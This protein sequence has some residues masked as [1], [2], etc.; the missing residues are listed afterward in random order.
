MAA[1]LE[2]LSA[3]V[4]CTYLGVTRSSGEA[5][6]W[7]LG[8]HWLALGAML[9]VAVVPFTLV[10]ILPINQ[11]LLDPSLDQRGERVA[12]LLTRWDESASRCPPPGRRKDRSA[13]PPQEGLDHRQLRIAGV[14]SP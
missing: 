14:S 6:R 13:N 5:T 12:E 1:Y 7:L 11:L 4:V 2:Q 3:L 9:L 8:D 10:V